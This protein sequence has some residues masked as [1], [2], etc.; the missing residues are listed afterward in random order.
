MG[1]GVFGGFVRHGGLVFGG[2]VGLGVFGGLVGFGVFGGFV[3]HGGLV[4]GGLV[5]FGVFGGFVGLGVFGGLVRHGGL[6][7]G[8]LVGFGVFGGFVGF[9]VFGGAP[10]GSFLEK[11]LNSRSSLWA[12][13][14][15]VV[16]TARTAS[17][18]RSRMLLCIVVVVH[19]SIQLRNE[20]NDAG[21][22]DWRKKDR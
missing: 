14:L 2:L 20:R 18:A 15:G 21:V 7:F 9:G 11:M 16:A 10:H 6:V 5:G 3:R 4:F 22:T 19:Q 13:K 8:G 12:L 17:R 1:F